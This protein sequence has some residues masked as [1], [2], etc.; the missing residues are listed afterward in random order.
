[1]PEMVG[2]LLHQC[3]WVYNTVAGTSHTSATSFDGSTNYSTYGPR[4]VLMDRLLILGSFYKMLSTNVHHRYDH[5]HPTSNTR[6]MSQIWLTLPISS[7][8]DSDQNRPHW[9]VPW[10]LVIV[11]TKLQINIMQYNFHSYRRN[12]YNTSFHVLPTLWKV[13]KYFM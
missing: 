13:A 6:K 5:N 8:C 7:D 2:T 10:I 4:G 9:I 11:N 1:M 3:W 12:L